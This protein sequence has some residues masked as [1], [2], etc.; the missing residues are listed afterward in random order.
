MQ[1]MK[2]SPDMLYIIIVRHGGLSLVC[3]PENG[4]KEPAPILNG[5]TMT[6]HK[7]GVSFTAGSLVKKCI[8][9]PFPLQSSGMD[10]GVLHLGL[11]L[12]HYKEQLGD[13]YKVIALLSILCFTIT[14]AIAYFFA[15]RLTSPILSL[16]EVTQKITAGDLSARAH[17]STG[18][19]VERLA[20]S[21]NKMT[22]TM[23]ESQYEM[24]SAYAEL[25]IYRKNLE[26]LVHQRTEQLTE[27]N[28]KLGQELNQR[29]RVENALTESEFRYRTIL[30]LQETPRS[31]KPTTL[32]P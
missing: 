18:D 21:F 23:A 30:R 8:I 25:E 16:Q 1:V 22:D 14:M 2:N 26:S 4:N 27:T 12:S 15:R 10:W 13:M 9:T 11:S 5:V 19:E 17:I 24:M 31:L 28:K 6:R 7:K 3:L 20:A 29:L 32:F